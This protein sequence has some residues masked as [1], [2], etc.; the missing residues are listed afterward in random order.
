MEVSGSGVKAVVREF[1]DHRLGEDSE[2]GP[3]EVA[4]ADFFRA[5]VEGVVDEQTLIDAS[6]KTRLARFRAGELDRID[7][8]VPAAVRA[9][10]WELLRRASYRR[11]GD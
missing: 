11:R 6:I 5:V 9:A 8:I 1:L 7:S 2:I 10:T 3:L 4:D